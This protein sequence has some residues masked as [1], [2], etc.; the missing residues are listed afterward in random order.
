MFKKQNI[1]V[2]LFIGFSLL[3]ISFSVYFYQVFYS[4]NIIVAQPGGELLIPKNATFKQVVDSLQKYRYLEDMVSFMFVAKVTGYQENVRPGRYVFIKEEGQK[5]FNNWEVV[6]TLRNGMQ[7]PVRLTFNNI[8]LK[9]DL[10]NRLCRPISAQPEELAA[11]LNDSAYVAE[12][13]FDTT[14]IV[15]L[16]CP[17]PMN[18][19]GRPTPKNS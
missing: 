11:L 7:T 10:I 17:I 15:S 14:N 8:R 6:R 3:T 2:A 19:T 5:G 4:P 13:G 12:L 18:F 9:E 16:F 1:K